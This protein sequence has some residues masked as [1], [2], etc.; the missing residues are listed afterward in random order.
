MDEDLYGDGDTATA[1]TSTTTSSPAP[2]EQAQE[3][4][5]DDIPPLVS[6]DEE[7]KETINF[8]LNFNKKNYPIDFGVDDSVA[9]LRSHIAS[10]TGVPAN[11]QKL[12]F[13]GLVKEDSKSLRQLGVVAGSKLMLVGSTTTQVQTMAAPPEQVFKEEEPKTE[14]LCEMK[15]HKKILD[16]GLPESAVRGVIGRNEALPSTPL[17]GVLNNIGTPVRLTFKVYSQELWVS[18]KSDTKTIPFGSIRAVVTEPIKGQEAYHIMSLQL[19]TSE[20]T[21]LFLYFVPAQ[22]TKAIKTAIM[23]YTG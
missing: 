10:L 1:T 12:M 7:P 6:R 20:N 3:D 14:L 19:G 8:T 15:K 2:A 11:L 4:L 21:R 5:V 16:K 9:N 13:K 22:Y 23:G 18:S 17:S